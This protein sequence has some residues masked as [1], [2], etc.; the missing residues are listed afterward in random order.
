MGWTN[1]TL[2]GITEDIAFNTVADLFRNAFFRMLGL[3]FSWR[4]LKLL[5]LAPIPIPTPSIRR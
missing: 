4:A 2:V 3:P 5:R 1:T